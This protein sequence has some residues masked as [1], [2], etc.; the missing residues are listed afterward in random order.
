MPLRLQITA[1]AQGRV[2]VESELDASYDGAPFA[3][4]FNPQYLVDVYRALETEEVLLELSTPLNPGVIRPLGDD[5]YK[6]VVMPMQ[7]T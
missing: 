5:R 2:E 3:I 7:L 6:Y 4:A 1:S